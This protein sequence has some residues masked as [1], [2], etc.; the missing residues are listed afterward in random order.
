MGD[1]V[2]RDDTTP[3]PER[4]LKLSPSS[5]A[6]L[7]DYIRSKLV[8]RSQTNFPK[9]PSPILTQARRDSRGTR[10]K[11]GQRVAK[12]SKL[13]LIQPIVEVTETQD[14]FPEM[15]ATRF[16]GPAGQLEDSNGA[17]NGR[18]PSQPKMSN[19]RESSA[20][21]V[22]SG[23]KSGLNQRAYGDT[24]GRSASIPN[25][26]D[27][28][29]SLASGRSNPSRLPRYHLRTVPPATDVNKVSRPNPQHVPGSYRSEVNH[30][31]ASEPQTPSPPSKNTL[32]R[33][34][35]D[36]FSVPYHT[37]LPDDHSHPA[38][39]DALK[40]LVKYDPHAAG[41]HTSNLNNAI[42]TALKPPS[43][44]LRSSL[45]DSS[46]DKNLPDQVTKPAPKQVDVA[47]PT[48]LQESEPTLFVVGDDEDQGG[49]D[50]L[51]DGKEGSE[52]AP[53]LNGPQ[54]SEL[55]AELPPVK[56]AAVPETI[57]NQ[58]SH[59]PGGHDAKARSRK[60]SGMSYGSRSK[61]KQQGGVTGPVSPFQNREGKNP[62][63]EPHEAALPF[64][65]DSRRSSQN[66]ARSS[67]ITRAM[68][69]LSE[70][71]ARS[72]T[73][74][75]SLHSSNG[76]KKIDSTENLTARPSARS[77][78]QRPG[79]S[80]SKEVSTNVDRRSR[81]G[82]IGGQDDDSM[83]DRQ[84]IPA[85]GFTKVITDMEMV[86]KEA[87]NIA[88]QASADEQKTG[89]LSPQAQREGFLRAHSDSSTSGTDYLS[90][91][92]EDVDEE[93]HG[94]TQSLSTVERPQ[95]HTILEKSKS[96]AQQKHTHQKLDGA[97]PHPATMRHDIEP[98]LSF[99]NAPQDS[100]GK[101]QTSS[102]ASNPY[103]AQRRYLAP[104]DWAVIRVPSR[105]SKL[106]L[107]VK[108]PPQ[109]PQ[110]PPSVKP[111]IKE[112][113]TF[114][115]RDHGESE[116]TLTR[117]RIQEYVQAHQRPPVQQRLSSRP[118]KTKD[119]VGR[120]PKREE[121]NLPDESSDD[122]GETDCE[123]VP[124]VADFE[125]SGLNYHPVFQDAAN[126][127]RSQGPRQG[128]R[129]FRPPQDSIAPL[130]SDQQKG[131]SSRNDE[132][133]P[134]TNTY[135]L[136]GRH[137]FSIREPRGFSLSRSHRRSPI[138]RDWST[139]RKRW[140]A[141]VVCI[142][143]AFIG[144]IIGIYAG[145]V[146]AIQYAIAD[147]HHYT[148]L[149]NVLFFIGMAITTALFYPLPLLHGRKPYT[150]GALAIL[151]PLQFPQAL[152]I[153]ANRSPYVAT[154][155]VGLLVP[156][157]FAGIVMGFANINFITTLLDLFGSSLQSGNPH[158][159]VVNENDVRRHGGGMGLWLSIWTWCFIGSLGL[160]FL[161]G[162]GIISG[163]NV[164]WGY[165]IL[166]ILNAGVLL[167]NI[168][169]PEVRRS[170]YRRS[171]AEVRSGNEV[172]RR[173][174]KGE[175]KMHLQSTGPIWWGEEV[176]AGHV[177]A[178]RMLKQPGFAV[179]ALYQGWIYGQVVLVIVLLGALLSKYYRFHPQYVGLAVGIIPLGALLA[180]PFEKAG[181]FSRAR[182]HPQRTDSMTFQ[183]RI[184][185][186]SHLV[187][188]AIFMISLPFAGLAY[189]LASGGPPTQYM[190]P[191]IFA[192]L[193]G[194]LS[195]L[196][197]AECNGIIME[198]FDTSDLQP[199]M[200]GR[201]RR[202]LPEE[203]RKKRT[204]FSCFPRVT[205]GFAIMQTF[206]FGIAA[207]VTAWG[208]VVER[209]VGAQTATAVMAG[210]LLVLTLLLLAA[211]WRFKTVQ[212]IPSERFGTNILSGPEDEWK[213]VII[214]NPSGTTRRMSLLELGNLSRWSEIRRRNK[215][216][217][218]DPNR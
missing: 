44:A 159:E 38:A 49:P 157:I 40:G 134:V 10:S 18:R 81:R 71:S 158:Q 22:W 130:S 51:H 54:V 146:P 74:T 17:I 192:G 148:I 112:Q 70:L 60:N 3:V 107:E 140:T 180:V 211:L 57:A 144:L 19:K 131:V 4:G 143:T 7:R 23:P 156:R 150:M 191:I 53:L 2:R 149:G 77:K 121:L 79:V 64:A 50:Y 111:P 205:A 73:K 164:S 80:T 190:V 181:L 100:L 27:Q 83:V 93:D 45:Q 141:T 114:L 123:C 194:F 145:E 39:V 37:D 89:L 136:E 91:D 106:R 94:T 46:A 63:P 173:V 201:P 26:S 113:H 185:W 128:Q 139:P 125:T 104:D 208:G 119:K 56:Q 115:V 13:S 95:T 55:L 16:D 202:I 35:D 171:M 215:L 29:T 133:P 170:A 178:I 204:N 34:N 182:H 216:A 20:D 151:L 213:P 116:D 109:A 99:Q 48:I 195:N 152:A 24:V 8:S 198:T 188:R 92:A 32:A 172:S 193:I 84:Q 160:G 161:I 183:K 206:A 199:G 36:V 90:S 87:L 184:T 101:P 120:V 197:I 52:Q 162:A 59:E 14:R 177:L 21:W 154:Y 127:E 110:T 105:P 41:H 153:D 33:I 165:W 196:A 6:H 76:Y 67:P 25:S 174:A 124:Y 98:T 186:T 15:G 96:E 9:P 108:P 155:R 65:S 78:T 137:H 129:P 69:M 166:I 97:V 176:F 163:L 61:R 168:I 66:P 209:H 214:G 210:V 72:R 68:S 11:A 187:R 207:A 88:G 1:D 75:P 118:L 31:N 169:A 132:P 58:K 179:L 28:K 167:L 217:P 212:I 142:T 189:T 86:L 203:V 175:I 200:T 42:S 85:E 62:A 47:G 102:E 135:N 218:E 12:P 43:E 138:A 103:G 82:T 30:A 5:D 117:T 126:G 122:G 147:E